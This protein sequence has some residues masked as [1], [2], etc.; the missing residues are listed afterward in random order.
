KYFLVHVESAGADMLDL[1]RGTRADILPV[2][3][4]GLRKVSDT[5]TPQGVIG[6]AEARP[7]DHALFERFEWVVVADRLRDP[8]NLG[9]LVRIGAAAKI[10]GIVAT[11]GSADFGHP[12]SV[13][14]SA[15]GYFALPHLNGPDPAY[16]ARLLDR[17]GARVVVAHAAADQ[18]LFDFDWSGRIALVI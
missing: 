9:A 11:R 15:G 13:R 4:D 14:A 17:S 7:E 2:S 18:D 12:R 5:T 8:G 16:L 1:M 6:V 3:F 10:D